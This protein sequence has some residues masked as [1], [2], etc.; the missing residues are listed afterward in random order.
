MVYQRKIPSAFLDENDHVNVQYYLRLVESWSGRGIPSG[1]PGADIRRGRSST[2]ISPWSSI[3][4]T[5]LK[6]SS[7]TASAFTSV[8]IELSAKRA[9]FMGFLV[10]EIA[11]A[12]GGKRGSGH[13]EC[14]HGAA[15]RRAFPG[16]ALRAS[17]DR[18]VGPAPGNCPGRAPDLRRDARL[19]PQLGSRPCSASQPAY[20]LSK[21]LVAQRIQVQVVF[22]IEQFATGS[23]LA[24]SPPAHR[25]TAGPA[26]RKVRA[27]PAA[28]W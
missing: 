17:C 18:H 3:F 19:A 27:S 13:D 24:H 7:L 9:Y 25:N 8:L 1:W 23:P 6:S 28:R 26:R 21:D 2:A 22:V 4:A 11:R 12:A 16:G 5:W 14:R 20:Q 10:N 15:A